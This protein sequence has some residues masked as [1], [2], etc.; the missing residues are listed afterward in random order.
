MHKRQ[1]SIIP[2]VFTFLAALMVV[3]AQ[4]SFE[5]LTGLARDLG[6]G[7]NGT[8]WAIGTDQKAYRLNGTTWVVSP[9]ANLTRVAIDP[10]GNPWAV[11]KNNAILRLVAA[12]WQPMPGQAFD[13]GIGADGTVYA[14]GLSNTLFRWNGSSWGQGFGSDAAQVAVDP[15]GNPWTVGKTGQIARYVAGKK[16]VLPGTALDIAVASNGTVLVI[17]T[18]ARRIWRW[19]GKDWVTVGEVPQAARIAAA[20]NGAAWIATQTG[21][22]LRGAANP[23]SIPNT[24]VAPTPTT[25]STA[26]A[27]ASFNSLV[28]GFPN[29]AAFSPELPEQN[30][31]TAASSRATQ[32]LGNNAYDCTTTPYTLTETP[33]KIVTFNPDANVL[34]AGAL[35]QGQGYKQGLGSL[36]ELPIRQRAPLELSVNLQTAGNSATIAN[37]TNVSVQAAIG[38]IID[39]AG[40]NGILPSTSVSY[41]KT[42]SYSS[43]QIALSLGVSVKYL[44]SSAKA[45]FDFKRDASER[46]VTAIFKETAFTVSVAAPQTPSSYLSSAFLSA[47]LNAQIQQG[48]LGRDNI[49]VYVASIT[50]GRMLMFSL[51]SK[52]SSQEINATLDAMYQGGAVT[53]EGNLDAKYKKV[54][55]ES[56]ISV[57]TVGGDAENARRL[58]AS[59]KLSDYF[60]RTN[61]LGTYK[62]MSYEVRNLGDGSIAKLSE[63][64]NYNVTECSV[65]TAKKVGERWVSVID[66][67]YLN[68]PGDD[69]EGN[70]FGAG[71]LVGAKGAIFNIPRASAITIK[72]GAVFGANRFINIPGVGAI[73]GDGRFDEN[74]NFLVRDIT[75]ASAPA[76]QLILILLDADY[77]LGN[78][79]DAIVARGENNP[80]LLP[81]PFGGANTSAAP[82]ISGA[83]SGSPG[84]ATVLY[85]QKK[86]CNLLE[87]PVSKRIVAEEPCMS[88]ATAIAQ[89]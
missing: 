80:I 52:A 18:D 2:V 42:D 88:A 61:S 50:Y 51:T 56:K 84:S 41:Q 11:G 58:I 31:A 33:D 30:R 49:P 16:E 45:T 21:A 64:T 87:E 82:R 5:R 48:N 43:E 36:K 73:Q 25:P 20:P 77:T 37:P 63:T 79:D 60:G 26:D 76:L 47:D 62:P 89:P 17:G 13:L 74:N 35:L 3:L 85:R 81:N 4:A 65:L 72:Q 57:V 22:I 24:V 28:L 71:F 83:G 39:N 70:I 9:S 44:A 86:L 12:K 66:G 32:T 34:W 38:G 29:W 67:I 75:S 53:V 1:L 14:V 23:N 15:Q 54:L 59:G 46:T 10:K 40:R 69:S 7:A 27:R 6:I 68:E 55:Q 19:T 78:A 8:A